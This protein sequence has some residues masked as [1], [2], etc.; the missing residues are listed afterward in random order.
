[1]VIAG[2]GPL[3]WEHISRQPVDEPLRVATEEYARRATHCRPPWLTEEDLRT[4][5]YVA[6]RRD[7]HAVHIYPETDSL[8]SLG[9]G[10]GDIIEAYVSGTWS[11]T[12]AGVSD[13]RWDDLI[14]SGPEDS[15]DD[16]ASEETE[17]AYHGIPSVYDGLD[18]D[19]ER[20]LRFNRHKAR[21][22]EKKD[23]DKGRRRRS[24]Q[25]GHGRRHQGQ[26]V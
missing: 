14:G 26:T 11:V 13:K 8:S 17:K 9:F 6:A 5:T 4:A 2:K 10:R 18:S 19:A 3:P 20:L 25:Q 21:R 12:A 23:A 7:R 1:M 16:C 22:Q 24:E 15:D